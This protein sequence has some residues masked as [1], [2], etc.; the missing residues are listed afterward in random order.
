MARLMG[1]PA[2]QE[3]RSFCTIQK[4]RILQKVEGTSTPRGVKAKP[5][6]VGA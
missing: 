1:D 6:A 3:N 2:I 4:W 5:L